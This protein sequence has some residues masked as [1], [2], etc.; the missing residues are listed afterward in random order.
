MAYREGET[1][2]R[3]IGGALVEIGHGE[4]KAR[5]CSDDG[6]GGGKES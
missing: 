6:C 2:E 4:L 1:I 5:W 3:E